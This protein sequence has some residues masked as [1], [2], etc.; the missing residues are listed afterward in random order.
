MGGEK[1]GAVNM[2]VPHEIARPISSQRRLINIE[3]HCN[4]VQTN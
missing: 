2:F 1:E 4:V 3:N